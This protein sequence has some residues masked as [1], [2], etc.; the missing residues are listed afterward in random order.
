MKLTEKNPVSFHMQIQNYCRGKVTNLGGRYRKFYPINNLYRRKETSTF[1]PIRYSC[2]LI[3][4]IHCYPEEL[5][6][7]AIFNEWL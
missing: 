4:V 1:P 5:K 2:T 6:S 7:F 3:Q